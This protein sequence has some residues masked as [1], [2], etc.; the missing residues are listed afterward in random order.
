MRSIRKILAIVLALCLCGTPAFAAIA[1]DNTGVD[2][3]NNGGTGSLTG[4]FTM[5]SVSNGLLTV[6]L[7]GDVAG[8][9]DDITGV[10]YN[11]VSMTLAAKRATANVS[12]FIYQYYLLAPASGAHN[13]VVTSTTNHYLIGTATSYSGVKQ[14]AQPDASA[15]NDT[16]GVNNTTLTTS[17]T[18]VADNSWT[19]L[20]GGAYDASPQTAGTGSTLRKTD[21]TNS[22][23]IF[24]SNAA[25]T[26]AGSTSMAFGMTGSVAMGAVLVSYAPYVAAGGQTGTKMLMGIG[27]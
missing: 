12:R 6:C 19:V 3:G 11:S 8:G 17:V 16:G 26:P 22:Q 1:I 10:T 7:V 15:T 20:C 21:A 25:K 13:V 23:T 4:A 5:G 18:T 9:A 2:L 27:K 14:S 24:D